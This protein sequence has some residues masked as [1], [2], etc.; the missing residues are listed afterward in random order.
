MISTDTI[1]KVRKNTRI[2]TLEID[3]KTADVLLAPNIR[4]DL[5]GR[6]RD[7]CDLLN[8]YAEDYVIGGSVGGSEDALDSITGLLVAGYWKMKEDY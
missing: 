6:R 2:R 3:S 7:N 8:F 1:L 5:G 4:S